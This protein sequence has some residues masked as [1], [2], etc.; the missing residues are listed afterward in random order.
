[1]I[2]TIR[3]LPQTAGIYQYFD[4]KGQLLYIGKAKNLKNRVKS[5]W[6]LT[7]SLRPNSSLNPRIFKMLSETVSMH[8]IVVNSEHD[9]LILENSLIKQLKP[10]Y[11][12]LLRDD[13]TYPYIYIDQTQRY[14]RFEITRKVIDSKNV[15]Y[16]GPFSVGAKELLDSIYE[17]TKLVQKKSCLGGK[18]ACLYY[19]IKKCLAP[20]E[21]NVQE[22]LYQKEIDKAIGFIENKKELLKQLKEKMFF[23]ADEL[24]FEEANEIKTRIQKIEKSNISSQID[25]ATNDNYDIFVVSHKENRA[26]VVRIFMRNGKIISSSHDFIYLN[27]GFDKDELYYR[28]LLE[29]YAKEIPP[30]IAPILVA[31]SFESEELLKEYLSVLFQRKAE[32]NVPKIGDKKRLIE[33]ALLNANE[34][35]SKTKVD[36]SYEL[37]LSLGELYQLQRVPLRIEVFDNS[38]MS[39]QA[40]VGAMAVYDGGTFD[41][42]SYRNYHLDS[43]DEYSQMREMLTKRIESFEKNTPPDLWVLDGGTTL[44]SLAIDLLASNGVFL[45]VIAISKEKIDAKS[46]RAKGEAK[47]I[48]HTKEKSFNLKTTDKRLQFVQRLRDE[49]HRLAITFHK[50]TKLKLDQESQLLS[51]N[52][53]SKAKIQKLL[54]Y[55]GTFEMIKHASEADIASLLNQKD[56]KSIKDSYK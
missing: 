48:V 19:Q 32:I 1:M 33:L 6:V 12:I 36:D 29:F 17:L 31:E 8:Y 3:N 18:K 54:N 45:D 14:P 51:L 40:T 5:Y 9:A 22:T 16:F 24:R 49:A 26:V 20:C 35:L 7:P 15:K 11:N 44:L 39:G 47:D 41:K 2:D 38:H 37:S 34:L 4:A 56:A 23:Y 21:F 28:A 52:G 50:K 43:R 27:E 46:H 30:I 25:L 53:I 13:K 10:K 42:K 55:F